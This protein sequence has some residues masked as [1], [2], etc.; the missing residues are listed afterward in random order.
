MGQTLDE[1]EEGKRLLALALEGAS[2]CCIDNVVY[3]FGNQYL[4]MAVTTQAMTGRLL[5]QTQMIN[6]P[7]NAV[8]F[9]TGNNLSYRGDMSRRVVPIALDIRMEKPEERSGFLHAQLEPWVM[10][11]RPHLVACALTIL[12]AYVV[13]GSPAQGL[14]PYGSFEAWSDLVRN[15]VVW[16]GEADPC[17]G[18]QD[19][20]AQMDE[21]YEQLACLLTTWEACYPLDATGTSTDRTINQVKQ[22]MALYAAASSAP[23]TTWDELRQA[24]IAFD[25]RYDGKTLDTTRVGNALRAVE[26]RVIGQ[27]RLKRHGEYRHNALWRVEKV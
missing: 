7:W 5:G 17:E 20:A 12:R 25:R 19:L 27:T 3:P 26:G 14:T 21:G 22:D 8:L 16:L 6:A 24:L 13:A 9:A 15:A 4:A 11:E 10:Q 1:A 18:R 2:V 23:P